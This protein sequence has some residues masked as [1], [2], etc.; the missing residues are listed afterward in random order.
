MAENIKAADRKQG[1]FYATGK[2]K[3]SVAR[4]WLTK[5]K[6]T[7]TINGRSFEEYLPRPS[8]R[9]IVVRPFELVEMAGKF[10]VN[11]K[12]H[13][14]GLSGQAGAIRHAIAKAL[15]EYD[16]SLKKV[17]KDAGFITRDSRVVERK[18]P[19]LKKARRSPQF[20]KR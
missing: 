16:E 8:S 18:K 3:D 4:L 20:S 14:G 11:V 13:G 5:G 7:V 17:L 9:M 19:G 6:G 10:D 1:R 2:R 15:V 12:V